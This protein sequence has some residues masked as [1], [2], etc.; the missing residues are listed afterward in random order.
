MPSPL[1]PDAIKRARLA[2]GWSQTDMAGHLIG[3]TPEEIQRLKDLQQ[4]LR[5]LREWEQG[6]HTP[7]RTHTNTLKRLL[8][9][10]D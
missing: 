9:L 4:A 8:R 7:D 6:I 2:R 10:D 3:A 1:T 5:Q